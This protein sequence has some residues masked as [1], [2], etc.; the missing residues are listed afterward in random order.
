MQKIDQLK[1][2]QKGLLKK[3]ASGEYLGTTLGGDSYTNTY[4]LDFVDVYANAIGN[5]GETDTVIGHIT[6]ENVV[7][8]SN[9]LKLKVTECN[10]FVDVDYYCAFGKA[11]AISSGPGGEK[12]S[13]VIIGLMQDTNNPENRGTI[14]IFLNTDTSL[15]ELSVGDD[16]VNADIR[17]P[18]SRIGHQW[19]IGG[20][21]TLEITSSSG[22]FE[23]IPSSGTDTQP[24]IEN[25]DEEESNGTV[26]LSSDTTT[27][28]VEEEEPEVEESNE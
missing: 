3:V 16:L 14:K 9:N 26:I 15:N 27:T 5:S 25:E 22:G 19:F 17:T 20:A 12:D 28:S 18:Q 7:T 2:N 13:M 1:P 6:M 24:I 11:R 10:L 8:R 4:R 21:A 23:V